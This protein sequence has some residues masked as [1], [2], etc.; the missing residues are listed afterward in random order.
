MFQCHIVL[1][2]HLLLFFLF[3]SFSDKENKY[4]ISLYISTPI[5][6]S[7]VFCI[8]ADADWPRFDLDSV[9]KVI[10]M[11]IDIFQPNKFLQNL[12]ITMFIIKSL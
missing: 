1:I 12:E 6:D 2:F 5:A 7:N 10:G 3:E 4:F 9:F 8:M 11:I